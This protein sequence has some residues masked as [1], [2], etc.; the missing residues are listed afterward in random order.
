M[1]FVK[2]IAKVHAENTM[3]IEDYLYN[4]LLS[5]SPVDTGAY[6]ANHN[7]SADKPDPSFNERVTFK[8]EPQPLVKGY[9]SLFITNG[10]PYAERLEEGWSDQAPDAPGG[11]IYGRALHSAS[12]KFKKL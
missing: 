11:A 8:I 3:K 9:K 2:D 1:A 12:V 10:A 5:N 4:F 7:R 6:R